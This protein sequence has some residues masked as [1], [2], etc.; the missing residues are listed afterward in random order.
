MWHNVTYDHSAKWCRIYS[1]Q[2]VST[3]L[4]GFTTDCISVSFQ[5]G[6]ARPPK[7]LLRSLWHQSAGI[8]HPAQS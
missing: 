5:P 8:T 3:T 4:A 1:T 6:P 2:R 7:A